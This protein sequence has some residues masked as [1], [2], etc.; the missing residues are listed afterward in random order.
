MSNI[1]QFRTKHQFIRKIWSIY[2]KQFIFFRKGRI[3]VPLLYFHRYLRLTP[4]LGVSFLF[5]MSLLRFLGNGPLWPSV[6][7]FLGSQCETN[8]WS[9]L[10]YI[11]NYVN[12][13]N[14][15]RFLPLNVEILPF[16]TLVC[17]QIVFYQKLRFYLDFRFFCSVLDIR[18]IYRYVKFIA[19]IF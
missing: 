11:Q 15:V 16:G 5:S 13:E 7:G 3:N 18:G 8:W 17:F 1:K 6:I 10:L 9:T 12:P 2:W 14:I 19:L 4:L